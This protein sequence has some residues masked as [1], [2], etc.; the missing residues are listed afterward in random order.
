MPSRVQKEVPPPVHA[1]ASTS[2]RHWAISAL[3]S[4]EI[5]EIWGVS[6]SGSITESSG[7]GVMFVQCMHNGRH[8]TTT[9][10]LRNLNRKRG[11]VVR[12]YIREILD[13][14]RLDSSSD[15]RQRQ[16]PLRH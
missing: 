2:K 10:P 8:K 7:R 5:E 11:G 12:V 6:K 16:M 3:H 4:R 13:L 1:L 15:K 9:T 14:I